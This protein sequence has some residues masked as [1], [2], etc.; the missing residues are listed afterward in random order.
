MV[1]QLNLPELSIADVRNKIKAVRTRHMAKSFPPA[2][3]Q[4]LL[5]F[6]LEIHGFTH[7]RLRARGRDNSAKSPSH[8]SR[9]I[10]SITLVVKI[11]LCLQ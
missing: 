4:K 6:F 1:E 3:H 2:V 5:N 10:I 11:G 9:E 7:Y 8:N